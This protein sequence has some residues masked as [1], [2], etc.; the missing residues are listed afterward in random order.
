VL[1]GNLCPFHY[2][3]HKCDIKPGQDVVVTGLWVIGMMSAEV[4]GA[5]GARLL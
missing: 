4:L 5:A 3:L 2:A 1:G